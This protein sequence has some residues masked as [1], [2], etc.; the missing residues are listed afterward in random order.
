MLG[1]DIVAVCL[2]M[3]K[4]LKVN[5]FQTLVNSAITLYPCLPLRICVHN[6]GYV[7]SAQAGNLVCF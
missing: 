6:L 5:D 1:C 3:S 7:E 4:L 2:S